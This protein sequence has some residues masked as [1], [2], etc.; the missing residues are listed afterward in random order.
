MRKGNQGLGLFA[1]CIARN[2]AVS[3][4]EQREDY[5]KEHTPGPW[6]FSAKLSGSENHRGFCIF[7]SNKHWVADASPRDE[8][9]HEGEAN[10]CLIAAAPELLR[11]LQWAMIFLP[12]MPLPDHDQDLRDV[13]AENLE[14]CNR[15]IAKAEG[16]TD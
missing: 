12:K 11:C 1:M 8:D 14:E 7:D 3:A 16:R 5:M 10:A 15:T 2:W 9:G 13:F 4:R 6:T